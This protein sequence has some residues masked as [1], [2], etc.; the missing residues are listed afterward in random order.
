MEPHLICLKDG[1][2]LLKFYIPHSSDAQYNGINQ[3]YWLQYHYG[4]NVLTSA[5][6]SLTHLVKPLDTYDAYDK[7]HNLI[8]FRQWV[9][10]THTSTYIHCPFDLTCVQKRISRDRMDSAL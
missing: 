6:R 2:F 5:S 3:W 4:S 8:A 7:H 1:W 9:T 10:L